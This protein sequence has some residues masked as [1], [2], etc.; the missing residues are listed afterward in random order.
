[1]SNSDFSK[2]ELILQMMRKTL[3]DI[4]KD[5]YTKPGLKHPLSE[6]TILGIRECL[7]VISAREA[8]LA[9]AAGRPSK[10]R[11][12]YVD[13]PKKSVVVQLDPNLTGKS[14]TDP[15]KK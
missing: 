14:S 13:E 7:S 12:R 4:A 15:D 9:E 10:H 2:E 3:T 5:T 8:E 1:M 11:P 6:Q